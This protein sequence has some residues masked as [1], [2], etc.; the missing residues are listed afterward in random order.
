MKN[1]IFFLIFHLFSSFGFSQETT[2]LWKVSHPE[3]N[4]TS[5]LLGNHHQIGDSF[6]NQYP[7][8]EEK[9]KSSDLLFLETTDFSAKQ[10]IIL[11]D[12]N[13]DIKKYFSRSNLKLIS[14]ISEEFKLL[15]Y[16]YTP[17]ELSWKLQQEYIKQKC[18]TITQNDSFDN[19]DNYIQYLAEKN[20]V[21]T[22]G[23]ATMYEQVE[24]LNKQYQ[25]TT[26]K[27]EKIKI[28]LLAQSINNKNT[29]R[30][31]LCY[32][33]DFD[34]KNLKVHYNF[35]KPCDLDVLLSE[36]NNKWLK[37]LVPLLKIKNTF[38]SVGFMHLGYNCGLIT[39]LRELGFNVE[40]V[41]MKNGNLLN[42]TSGDFPSP[43]L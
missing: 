5:Y 2:I 30:L 15:L 43:P 8:I 13:Y 31:S 12:E 6:I 36:R 3:S 25:T 32:D 10:V 23:F 18:G 41:E 29:V 1:I 33:G 4:N 7:I 21:P 28:L 42:G 34:I 35:E 17:I 11:R 27:S 19:F 40:P 24:N 22:K 9:I 20:N 38:T 37:K 14:N 26:W 39:Q 16:K